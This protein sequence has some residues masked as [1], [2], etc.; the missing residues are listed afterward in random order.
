MWT[1]TVSYELTSSF[2][3]CTWWTWLKLADLSRSL[4][5]KTW[6][7]LLSGNLLRTTQTP[8][9]LVVL[10]AHIIGPFLSGFRGG[11]KTTELVNGMGPYITPNL[12]ETIEPE[13]VQK[14]KITGTVFSP[15]LLVNLVSPNVSPFSFALIFFLTLSV[16]FEDKLKENFARGSA[17]LEKR[18]LAL[19]EAQRKERDRREKEE[20][21]AQEKREREARE[22]ENRRRLEE[23]RRLER[24]REVERQREEE[25]LRE[26]ERKEVS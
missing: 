13:P 22:L 3:P 5:L 1:G 6:C 16:S 24:Q 14:S 10:L 15:N 7:L 26:L 19:V 2:W 12:I 17:E 21:E 11:I 9:S 18:R 25:R 4:Y 23:E 20:R 8:G